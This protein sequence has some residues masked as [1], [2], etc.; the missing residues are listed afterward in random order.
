M[1]TCIFVSLSRVM[2]D[3]YPLTRDLQWYVDNEHGFGRILD[4]GV[5]QPRFGALYSW[6][7]AEL[8]TPELSA[9]VHNGV[10][11]HSWDAT[12]VEPWKPA[13]GRFV[14]VARSVL[15]AGQ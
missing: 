14:R 5:I 8:S 10:P 11:S 2:P 4:L 6:S 1:V 9:L 3:R 13:T 12:D 15:P 7:A